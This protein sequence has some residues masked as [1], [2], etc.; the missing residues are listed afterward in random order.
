M[1][2]VS[3]ALHD[4]G[5]SKQAESFDTSTVVQSCVE[6]ILMKLIRPAGLKIHM[7]QKTTDLWV[8]TIAKFFGDLYTWSYAHWWIYK[9]TYKLKLHRPIHIWSLENLHFICFLCIHAIKSLYRST[10]V[11]PT[12]Y[13]PTC[14]RVD[15]ISHGTL[16]I[17]ICRLVQIFE[18][19]DAGIPAPPEL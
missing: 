1:M 19:V 10:H 15:L 11:H 4:S 5:L 17:Q 12:Q 6:F 3:H 13:F 2:N 14:F 16:Q 18:S 9:V 7:F 8:P